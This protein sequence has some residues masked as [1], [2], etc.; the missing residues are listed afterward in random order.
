MVKHVLM[1]IVNVFNHVIVKLQY[2]TG[3]VQ[4]DHKTLKDQITPFLRSDLPFLSVVLTF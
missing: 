3:R 2:K 1:L 4:K